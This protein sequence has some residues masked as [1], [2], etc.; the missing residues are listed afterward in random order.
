MWIE[1]KTNWLET[2]YFNYTDYNRIKNN[3]DYLRELALS[4]YKNFP[5]EKFGSDKTGYHDIPYADE[6]NLIERD[7]EYIRKGTYDFFVKE[8][9]EWKEN[10]PT[11]TYQDFNRIE[12][13]CLNLY[14]GLT[15]QM[16]NKKRL[17]IRLGYQKGMIKV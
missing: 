8:M 9:K 10:Q 15:S 6:F 11:P 2:D 13:A 12:S 14:N 16:E 1:P 5:F 3:I 7:L 17:G 4:L